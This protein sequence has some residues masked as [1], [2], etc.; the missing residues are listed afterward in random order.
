MTACERPG[1]DA[2]LEYKRALRCLC[3]RRG[4]AAISHSLGGP[5][6]W[7][8]D[9]LLAARCLGGEGAS[10]VRVGMCRVNFGAAP[11]APGVQSQWLS[12]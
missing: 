6:R 8:W 5:A 7:L 1:G 2:A 11:Q 10:S 3:R 9:C 4:V 12:I